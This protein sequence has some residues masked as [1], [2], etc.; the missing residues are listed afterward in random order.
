MPEWTTVVDRLGQLAGGLSAASNAKDARIASAQYDKWKDL[1]LITQ[2]YDIAQYNERGRDNRHRENFNFKQYK[3]Q[4]EPIKP[5]SWT[6][7]SKFEEAI[8][9][10]VGASFMNND[11]LMSEGE[12][13]DQGAPLF[14]E[15]RGL[16]A[17]ALANVPEIHKD[18][19][20]VKAFLSQWMEE[21]DPQISFNDNNAFYN[22]TTWFDKETSE[23]S[24]GG[25]VAGEVNKIR[26]SLQRI[27]NPTQRKAEL[28]R[29][30]Q[31]LNKKYGPKMAKRLYARIAGGM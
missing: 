27:T 7:T 24:I 26:G 10:A 16:A 19:Q 13:T 12:L 25:S 18:P 17:E 6:D 4:N 30:Q 3:Y 5:M 31:E 20:Q 11:K 15:I 29:V 9:S 2:K 21:Y 1:A 28:L 8:D 22:P 14:Q 23:F